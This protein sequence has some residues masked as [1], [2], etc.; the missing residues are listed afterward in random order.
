VRRQLYGIIVIG[1]LSLVCFGVMAYYLAGKNPRLLLHDRLVAGHG[2]DVVGYEVKPFDPAR[3]RRVHAVRLAPHG[4]RPRDLRDDE[5]W[6]YRLALTIDGTLM[7]GRESARA[8]YDELDITLG[9]RPVR[10]YARHTLVF[11]QRLESTMPA[12]AQSLSADLGTGTRARLIVEG[13]R[14]GVEVEPGRKP[15]KAEG[16]EAEE[17]AA[18]TPPPPTPRAVAEAVYER[19]R[20]YAYVRVVGLTDTPTRFELAEVVRPRRRR[21]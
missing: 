2:V 14:F 1:V 21:N 13:G 3:R 4:E 17:A 8:P 20:Q 11:R 16:A 19:S 18:Q 15:M 9:D 6:S 5:E 7:E 10:T 12:L